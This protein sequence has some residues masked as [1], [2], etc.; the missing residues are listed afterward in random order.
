MRA[1]W[2]RRLAV[3][4]LA[5]VMAL[6]GVAS[7]APVLFPD[8]G[9]LDNS[10]SR[11]THSPEISGSEVVW[12][13]VP[14]TG[15]TTHYVNVYNLASDSSTTIGLNDGYNQF[16]PD[17]SLERVAFVTDAHG[18]DDVRVRDMRTLEYDTAAE[19]TADEQ[20]PRIDGNLVAWWVPAANEL[21]YWDMGRNIRGDVPGS[22]GTVSFSPGARTAWH[23][24]PLGQTLILTAGV[25]RVQRWEGPVEEIR[26]GDVVSIA[27]GVKHWHGA[28]PTTAMTH[29]A[30]HEHLDGKAAEWME[31]VSDEQYQ[32]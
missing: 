8:E 21:R 20:D 17:L 9:A 22:A 32:G 7:G 14:F 16:S 5:A 2:V 4:T 19:T 12:T 23:S 24:H 3:L 18:N 25:G 31:M 13:V 15:D 29:I 10:T 30:I 28:A 26:A 11:R 1:T 27:P 6:G